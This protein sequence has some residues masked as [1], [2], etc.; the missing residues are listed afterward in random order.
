M[1]IMKRGTHELQKSS[2]NPKFEVE[3]NSG[4][5]KEAIM[6]NRCCLRLPRMLHS[7][8][9]FHMMAISTMVGLLLNLS[10]PEN[11]LGME[12]Y[13]QVIYLEAQKCF[14]KPRAIF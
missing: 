11:R 10:L 9:F 2:V 12:S 14:V 1:R 5:P 6:A 7:I 3:V 13:Y 4:V 8:K